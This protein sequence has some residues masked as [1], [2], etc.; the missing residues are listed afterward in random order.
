MEISED[1]ILLMA[2]FR[3]ADKNNDGY[4]TVE[5]LKNALKNTDLEKS[6]DLMVLKADADH[7]GKIDYRGKNSNFHDKNDSLHYNL[8]YC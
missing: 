3:E 5:E 1:A 2:G 7:N 6:V 8:I 4:L